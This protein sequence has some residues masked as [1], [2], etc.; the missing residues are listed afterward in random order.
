MDKFADTFTVTVDLVN[1]EEL[2][3]IQE[4][5]QQTVN[6]I[7]RSKYNPDKNALLSILTGEN[8]KEEA[9]E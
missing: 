4:R 5:A 6:Y 8:V 1:Y 2:I 3:R 9:N 7:N